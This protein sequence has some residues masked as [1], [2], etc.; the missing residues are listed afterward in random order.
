MFYDWYRDA[1]NILFKCLIYDSVMIKSSIH[2]QQC[3]PTT[4]IMTLSL[5]I[6][7]SILLLMNKVYYFF[8][9]KYTIYR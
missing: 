7:N 4:I 5:I 9:I 2:L 8:T 6:T 3:I 1:Y